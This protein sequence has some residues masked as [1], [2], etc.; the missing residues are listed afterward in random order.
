MG[1]RSFY[2]A[3]NSITNPLLKLLDTRY[4]DFKGDVNS[5]PKY[6]AILMFMILE[7]KI[8]DMYVTSRT[9]KAKVIGKLQVKL[10]LEH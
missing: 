4:A 9:D 3:L 2:Y 5:L 8:N 7:I 1:T 10:G 6:V